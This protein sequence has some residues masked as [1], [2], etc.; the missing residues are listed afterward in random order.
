MLDEGDERVAKGKL[1]SFIFPILFLVFTV[2]I[3]IPSEEYLGNIGELKVK[4]VNVAP[5]LLMTAGAVFTVLVLAALLIRKHKKL[6]GVFIDLVFGFTLGMYIQSNFLNAGLEQLNG[7]E[8]VWNNTSGEAILSLSVWILCLILPHI[9]RL[10]SDKLEAKISFYGSI[11]LI[12]MQVASFTGLLFTPAQ[13]LQTGTT[14]S[15]EKEFELSKTDNVV[16]FVVDTLDAQWAEEYIIGDP[17]YE[18]FLEDYTYFDNVVSGG[19]PTI[20][21]IPAMLTGEFYDLSEGLMPFIRQANGKNRLFSDLK[22][23]HFNIRLYTDNQYLEGERFDIIDNAAVGTVYRLADPVRFVKSIYKVTAYI[24][25]PYQFKRRFL[26]YSAEI[27]NNV[28]STDT[29]IEVYQL[30]DPD[31]YTDYKANGI[32][33]TSD[34]PVFVL[35]HLFGA[36]GPYSMNENAER[37]KKSKT[38]LKQ[39]IDGTMKII[40][41]YID[42]MKEKGIYDSS[43]I[44]ITADHGGEAL[45][46][47][48]AVFVKR[49]NEHHP[50]AV[51]S[52][53]LTFRNLRATFAEGSIADYRD[54]YGPGMFDV[55]ESEQTELRRHTFDAILYKNV[56]PNQAVPD[57]GYMICEVGSPARNNDLLSWEIPQSE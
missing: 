40:S 37:V 11:A 2:F 49:R 32:A 21:G 25:M 28:E 8:I 10:I 24:G 6:S 3:Y 1:K 23:N 38:S 39:Q 44:I 54:K 7:T 26:I 51:S 19:A 48:P 55:E 18:Q 14:L 46:Q 27:T 12:L 57:S 29:G 22:N 56:Y 13:Q 5:F 53:P 36:H 45:Y 35:Y 52:V 15:K 31:F 34:E 42:E 16:V 30:D 4:Y 50:F 20:L 41:E 43:T 47:N 17:R 9:I 33:L